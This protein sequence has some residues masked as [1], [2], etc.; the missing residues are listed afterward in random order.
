[1]AFDSFDAFFA[2]GGHGTYVWTCYAVSFMLAFVLVMWS[3]RQHQSAVSGLSRRYSEDKTVRPEA[4][5]AD[6]ARVT[7]QTTDG[8][9]NASDS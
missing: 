6:F 8:R 1:M 4:V 7:P 2:M 5:S 3:R 9:H